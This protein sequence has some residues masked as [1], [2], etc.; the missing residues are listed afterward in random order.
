MSGPP[1]TG[2]IRPTKG[3][4]SI[5]ESATSSR[6]TRLTVS[7]LR[8]RGFRFGAGFAV[9]LTTPPQPTANA[10]TSTNAV[11][12][13]TIRM[14]TLY[15]GLRAALLFGL[16]PLLPFLLLFQQFALAGDVAAVAFRQHV[17]ADRANILSRNDFGSD[18]RLHRHLELLT[19]DEL[20]EFGGHLVAVGRGGILVHDSAESVDGHALQQDV[21]LYQ[22]SL[23]LA[24]FLVIE[25]CVAA[26]AR[27]Q[28]IEEVEDDFAKRHG[29]AQFDPLG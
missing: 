11:A 2:G 13:P 26:G 18:R 3:W 12:D 28:Q 8:S 22:R 7:P 25:A 21:D 5:R 9:P 6:G 15:L 24:G 19:R 10:A 14:T 16:H 4:P 23:L 17:F 1:N 29:V 27:F 20:F